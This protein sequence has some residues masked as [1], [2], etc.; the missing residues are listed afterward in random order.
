VA[1]EPRDPRQPS[2]LEH[3]A[4]AALSTSRVEKIRVSPSSSKPTRTIARRGWRDGISRCEPSVRPEKRR[5]ALTPSDWSRR[6]LPGPRSGGAERDH[7][8][9]LS[10]A[11]SLAVRL[12]ETFIG[13]TTD[14]YWRFFVS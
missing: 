9:V 5:S 6:E 12:L 1:L 8:R 3:G 14:R 4:E 7:D 13:S 10:R 2:L 11:L